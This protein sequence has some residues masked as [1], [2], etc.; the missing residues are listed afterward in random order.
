[1][2]RVYAEVY[3]CPSN[4]SDFETALGLLKDAGYEIVDSSDDSDIDIIFTCTVKEPT[5]KRMVQR[6]QEFSSSKKPLVVAGCMPKVQQRMIERI[7]RSA[8]LIGPNVDSIVR[9]VERALNG[10]KTI[11]IP[12]CKSEKECAGKVRKN[13]KIGIFK[14]SDGCLSDCSYCIVKNARGRLRS[15]PVSRIVNE[16]RDAIKSGCEEIWITSQD[17]GCY[18][19]DIGTNLPT[20]LNEIIKI[21]G[22]HTIRIGM[23]NPTYVK[24][25]INE[26]I[27]VYRDSK[28]QKFLHIPVQSGSDRILRLMKRNYLV[29]DFVDIANKFRNEFPKITISTDIIVGFPGETDEDFEKTIELITK[30][31]PEKVNLSKYGKRTGTAASDM[32]Q[33]SGKVVNQRSRKIS[34]LIRQTKS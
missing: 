22:E 15:Y 18:G 30:I 10:D 11:V 8:S 12:D 23:M 21:D 25:L 3:G 2:K 28:V 16:V 33:L 5:E 6:I 34:E 24:P 19:L 27:E 14:I 32:K 4:I 31:R 7:S 17:N 13:P 20:L 29:G 26:L 1:M 9:V